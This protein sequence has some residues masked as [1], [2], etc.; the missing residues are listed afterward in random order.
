M[1]H[2]WLTLLSIL[3]IQ[4]MVSCNEAQKFVICWGD[5]LSAPWNRPSLTHGSLQ[6]IFQGNDYPYYLQEILGNEYEVIN[7]AVSGEN[8]LTIMGRQGAYPMLLAHD[9]TIIKSSKK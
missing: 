5:S 1:K 3:F 4:L 8:T 6:S 2:G 9:V 7:A